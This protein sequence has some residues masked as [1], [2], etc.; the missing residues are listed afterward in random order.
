[1]DIPIQWSTTFLADVV[2]PTGFLGSKAVGEPPILMS[3]AVFFATKDAIYASRTDAN[4][5]GWVRLDAP[6]T[7]AQVRQLLPTVAQLL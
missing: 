2:N 7:P 5:K 1:M 4:V 6:A 3:A